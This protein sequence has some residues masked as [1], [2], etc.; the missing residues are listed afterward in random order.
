ML[1]SFLFVQVRSDEDN[2]ASDFTKVSAVE[3]RSDF[4]TN[5]NL[6][7]L[8]AVTYATYA[9]MKDDLTEELPFVHKITKKE[10][11]GGRAEPDGITWTGYFEK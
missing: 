10:F 4:F 2:E 3:H 6:N 8:D 11:V 1:A 7:E 5:R 9:E